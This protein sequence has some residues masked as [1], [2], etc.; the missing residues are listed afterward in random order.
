[1]DDGKSSVLQS[2][3]YYRSSVDA[4]A[5]SVSEGVVSGA[6]N[7]TLGA[8][9]HLLNFSN[10]WYTAQVPENEGD[11]HHVNLKVADDRVSFVIHLLISRRVCD[12]TGK[13]VALNVQNH[14]LSRDSILSKVLTNRKISDTSSAL[15]FRLE[16]ITATFNRSDEDTE[17]PERPTGF[18]DGMPDS[19]SFIDSSK[20]RGYSELV[21]V[22][23]QI[24]LLQRHIEASRAA[25]TSTMVLLYGPPGT[26]KTSIVVSAAVEN[27]LPVAT[28]TTANLGGEFIGER[29]QN[30]SDLFDYLE[31]VKSDF[32]LFIDEADSFL[33]EKYENN[34]Q[35]RLIRV[36]TINRMLRLLARNDRVT[37][38][39]MLAT[40]YENRIARDVAESCFKLYLAAPSTHEQMRALI[41]FYR[42]RNNMNITRR[43]LD[44][45]TRTVTAL[46]YAPGHVSLLMQRL[47]TNTIIKLLNNTVSVQNVAVGI[48]EQPVYMVEHNKRFE[49]VHTDIPLARVSDEPRSESED[50][51]TAVIWER[52]E[53]VAFPIPDLNIDFR[54][55]LG[56]TD[57]VTIEPP[58]SLVSE[59]GITVPPGG[60]LPTTFDPGVYT[61]DTSSERLDALSAE[62]PSLVVANDRLPLFEP[63]E[64]PRAL[65]DSEIQMQQIRVD[66]VRSTSQQPLFEDGETV[67]GGGNSS[68]DPFGE[69]AFSPFLTSADS[70]VDQTLS[71]SFLEFFQENFEHTSDS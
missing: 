31:K 63:S 45:I 26:G 9:M 46:G 65:S 60:Q 12:L 14:L 58:P 10:I 21:G 33:P 38:L 71:P 64:S 37:R 25:N 6:Y 43:Q 67:N 15:L 3:E 23:E 24:S 52:G 66:D 2:L 17:R 34:T 11:T 47:L 1:M 7:H 32:M 22:D 62:N 13:L 36:L 70:I 19:L 51:R 54:S 55:I 50:E 40:N 30:V 39:I 53:A 41:E 44:Y 57:E 59:L 69:L 5:H 68:V 8:L 56:T 61:N 4:A 42:N 48:F 29:E 35:A 49:G 27:H 18:A 28:V 16:N 20:S